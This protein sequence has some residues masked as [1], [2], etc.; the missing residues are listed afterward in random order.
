MAT[1]GAEPVLGVG[2]RQVIH[3]TKLFHRRGRVTAGGS[4]GGTPISAEI[5]EWVVIII[6]ATISTTV[7]EWI[8]ERIVVAVAA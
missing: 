5:S 4:R 8:D 7:A 3:L 1:G 6:T 2:R